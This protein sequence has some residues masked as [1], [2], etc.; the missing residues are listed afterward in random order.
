ME[1]LLFIHCSYTI[2]QVTSPFLTLM[3][4]I[5]LLAK[6]QSTAEEGDCGRKRLWNTEISQWQA[7][8][9]GHYRAYFAAAN[10]VS[11]TKKNHCLIIQEEWD[12][13]LTVLHIHLVTAETLRGVGDTAWGWSGWESRKTQSHIDIKTAHRQHYKTSG[14]QVANR[15]GTW[16]LHSQT[17]APGC[18]KPR[19]VRTIKPT[20][21]N[22]LLLGRR[23][24]RVSL[25]IPLRICK[26]LQQCC[27]NVYR[28]AVVQWLPMKWR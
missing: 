1:I 20:F 15:V 5:H 16:W 17:S 13:V 10:I 3:T 14:S 8:G 18:T 19:C 23:T 9:E 4:Q 11:G 24:E 2:G 21:L 22:L 6:P 28:K 27:H 12:A 25:D 7:K 26:K